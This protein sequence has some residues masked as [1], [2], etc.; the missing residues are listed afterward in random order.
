MNIN[1]KY[2]KIILRDEKKFLPVGNYPINKNNIIDYGVARLCEKR[3]Q[4][5]WSQN[6]SWDNGNKSG[7]TEVRQSVLGF[8][9]KRRRDAM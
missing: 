9:P 2:P 1:R 6:I 4:I 5:Y 8:P 3:G 7:V